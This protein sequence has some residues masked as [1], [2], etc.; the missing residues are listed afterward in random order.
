MAVDRRIGLILAVLLAC[1]RVNAQAIGIGRFVQVVV[2]DNTEADR[3][4]SFDTPSDGSLTW[5]GAGS[6]N[7]FRFSGPVRFN[8]TAAICTSG[9]GS[10]EG[11][12]AAPVGSLYMRTDGGV[13]TTLY[14]KESGIG[15]TGWVADVAA[16]VSGSGTTNQVAKFTGAT[17]IGS[18]NISDNGTIVTVAGKRVATAPE[19]EPCRVRSTRPRCRLP[20]TMWS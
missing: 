17:T 2:G 8:N 12:V 15:N 13:N 5:L 18:S 20:V 10:P 14:I 19:T 3:T 16:G 9:T 1:G 11:V 7:Q 4:I 6:V